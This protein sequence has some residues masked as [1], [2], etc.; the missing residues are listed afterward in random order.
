MI[1]VISPGDARSVVSRWFWG[2]LV[3]LP[4]TLSLIALASGLWWPSLL[5]HLFSLVGS[6]RLYQFFSQ[7]ASFTSFH[8]AVYL[9]WWVLVSTVPLCLGWMHVRSKKLALHQALRSIA[10]LNLSNGSWDPEK[11]TLQGGRIR[12]IGGVALGVTLALTSLLLAQELSFC[13]GCETTSLLGSALLHW[14]ALHMALALSYMMGVYF[15]F[16]R[17]IRVG[18]EA[19]QRT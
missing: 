3:S 7:R 10:R 19:E 14:A 17:S 5:E 18:L 15:Y 12:L 9:Y 4:V 16:W 8:S 2:H 11:W 13:K 1:R 6:T